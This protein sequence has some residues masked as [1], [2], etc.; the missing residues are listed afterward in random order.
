MPSN[1]FNLCSIFKAIN[2]GCYIFNIA[3]VT[4][5]H[6]LQ[7]MYFNPILFIFTIY[8][9]KTKSLKKEVKLEIT[10]M[11]FMNVGRAL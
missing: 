8:S 3:I 4:F 9:S 10:M 5:V 11:Q 2:V 7:Y 6:S 1:N